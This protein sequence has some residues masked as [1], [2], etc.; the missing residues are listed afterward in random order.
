MRKISRIFAILLTLC[1]L[2]GTVAIFA[3]ATD[4]ESQSLGYSDL[5]YANDHE[6]GS[7]GSVPSYFNNGSGSSSTATVGIAASSGNQYL[8]LKYANHAV[9]TKNLRKDLWLGIYADN[10]TASTAYANITNGSIKPLSSYSYFS[11]DFDI[12]ADQYRYLLDES[13]DS[14]EL[15]ESG[16]P[17]MKT[18]TTEHLSESYP[19]AEGAYGI[20][21]AYSEKSYFELDMRPIIAT[22]TETVDEATGT[23]TATTSYSYPGSGYVSLAVT[24]HYDEDDGAWKIYKSKTSFTEANCLGT[25]SNRLGEWNHISYTVKVNHDKIATSEGTLYLNGEKLR[26]QAIWTKTSDIDN[27]VDVLP[28]AIDWTIQN[29]TTTSIENN[30]KY[31]MAIDNWEPR[32]YEKGYSSGDK[33]GIDD[34]YDSESEV[35]S[36][37]D[38]T[39]VVYNKNYVM[40]APNGYAELNGKKLYVSAA[41]SDFIADIKNGDVLV[42]SMDITKLDPPA[43]T[44]FTVKCNPDNILTLSDAAIKR[45]VSL[46]R[47]PTGY[48]VSSG[49]KAN[50]SL[51]TDMRFNLYL[52][53]LDGVEITAVN[54]AALADNTFM[55][56]G[57]EHFVISATPSVAS[58]DAIEATVSYTFD[59]KSLEYK[60]KLDPMSYA[61]AVA[62]NYECGSRESR[63]IYEMVSY[64]K[65]IATLLSPSFTDTSGKLDSFMAIYDSHESCQCKST[66]L[67]ISNAEKAVDY[68]LLKEKGVTGIAYKLSLNEIGMIINVNE[69]VSVT[70]VSYTNALGEL[71]TH[72]AENGKLT[73]KNGYYL[74]SG[75][76][77]A[78]IDEIMTITVDGATGTYSLGKYI[79][80]NPE[81]EVAK[82]IYKYSIAAEKYKNT[83]E[84][85]IVVSVEDLRDSAIVGEEY[86]V[87]GYFVGVS[88]EGSATTVVKELILKDTSSDKLI[89][90]HGVPYGSDYNYG[91]KKGDLVRIYVT[92]ALND[93]E[94]ESKR[95]AEFIAEKNPE[96]IEDTIISRGNEVS[97]RLDEAILVENWADMQDLFNVATLETYTYV[98]L[99]GPGY[100]NRYEKTDLY[101]PH[102]NAKATGLSTMK[103]DTKRAL[104]FRGPVLKANISDEAWADY[105]TDLAG[106]PGSTSNVHSMDLDVY[107]V[108]TKTTTLNFF[109]TVLEDDWFVDHTHTYEGEFNTEIAATPTSEGL[110]Y[111]K[112]K[113][114]SLR[115][116]RVT[117]TLKASRL[118][119]TEL[120]TKT[121]YVIGDILDLSGMKVTAIFNDG[122][123]MDVTNLITVSSVI[124]DSDDTVI[125]VDFEGVTTKFEIEVGLPSTSVS[126]IRESGKNGT[127]Y[128]AEGYFVGVAQDGPNSPYQ[129]L[130]KDIDSDDLIAVKGVSYGST[131]NFGYKKGD[132]I[133]I[134]GTL[135]AEATTNMTSKRYLA[136]DGTNPTDIEKTIVS[137]G[138]TVT[139]KL[140]N[141][142]TLDSWDDWKS[143]F[144]VGATDEYTYVRITQKVYA[145]RY[146]S[147]NDSMYMSRLTTSSTATAASALKTDGTRYVTFRDV[148]FDAN[149]E[150]GWESYYDG[151]LT[152]SVYP[153]LEMVADEIIAVYTGATGY[154]YQLTVLDDSWFS[155]E[156]EDTSYSQADIVT[157]VA[158]AYVNRGKYIQYNQYVSRRHINPS[159]EAAT[160]QNMIYLDCSSFANAVY[161]EAFGV[162]V[163][164]YALT[165]KIDGVSQT[166]Q[167]G[168]FRNYARDNQDNDDVVGYWLMSASEDITATLAEISG[169]LEAGDVLNYRKKGDSA[170]H[171]MIYIG[172]GNFI[173]CTGDDFKNP[174][175]EDYKDDENDASLTFDGAASA[176]K[177]T[178]AIRLETTYMNALFTDTTNSR[179]LGAAYDVC[180]IR[181]LARGLTPTEKTVNRMTMRGLYMEKACDA[182]ISTSVKRGDTITYTVTFKNSQPY[183]RNIA[184]SEL[185]SDNVSFVSATADYLLTG[186]NLTL[187]VKVGALKTVT[188]SF[189]VKVNENAE[190]GALI[191]SRSTSANGVLLLQSVNTVSDYTADEIEAIASKAREYAEN[192][193][194]FADPILMAKALYKDALGVDILD[195]ATALELLNEIIDTTNYGLNEDSEL[196]EMV[197]PYLYGGR[198]VGNLYIR[199]NEIIRLITKSNISVGDII[200]AYDESE[201]R[202][203]AYVYVGGS[204]LIKISSTDTACVSVTMT[205]SQYESSHI[206]V[207]LYAYDKYVILRPSMASGN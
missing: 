78:Y 182:G 164:P 53:K 194:V 55:I 160:A 138:N 130:L 149:L 12:A 37:I 196:C 147:G 107:C 170:G 204:E 178:G 108:V 167:T 154:Y 102:M 13:V 99:K 176:E 183:V 91:Y 62:K 117:D 100:I 128:R 34:L 21:L 30:V 1:L 200:M 198:D 137:R 172:D 186:N 115:E 189:T 105:K 202:T 75:V 90:V 109:L 110:E 97:Y 168:R 57:A 86:L 54:G 18:V 24:M 163:M 124:L 77:A 5:G 28:H 72:T 101:R 135:T 26:T 161:Y 33:D 206:L 80:N 45:G 151:T 187:N 146:K 156:P 152:S 121:S 7:S 52:P 10:K 87:Q 23:T 158:K 162:N 188:V 179:Y 64:K 51:F 116:Y 166:P 74:V 42:S 193:T 19:T 113:D 67:N 89:A 59:G 126:D 157:E 46:E 96:S 49:I 165:D 173:H 47:T 104:G 159:P 177:K 44:A 207:T 132:R 92:L 133:R 155:F 17:I 48:N 79:D 185:L 98:H 103:P 69:G 93:D 40:P 35:S 201:G 25:L 205:D 94:N 22:T 50:M 6:S 144:K 125:T 111:R 119:I 145:N 2:S 192:G 150:E 195:Y 60:T 184:L 112:C 169:K 8:R 197:V 82:N 73:K 199:N 171:V 65:A 148:I 143:T 153:G 131:Y 142:V 16:N 31:S 68:S 140:D 127:L 85:D 180:I 122:S 83:T 141:V 139:Y 63:L 120:P 190:A 20:R 114:C 14:G 191:E 38:C 11:L 71:I 106:Y 174:A 88:D 43:W 203:I 32:Y 61:S 3:A 9:G 27:I 84:S 181:P 81:V 4:A 95:Y 118:E 175:G 136:F 134:Y 70:S 15:D 129:L 41:A 36:L 39:D 76:S 66:A 123:K 56:N 29:S 58:F